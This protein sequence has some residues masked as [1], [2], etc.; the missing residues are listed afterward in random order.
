MLA[1]VAAGTTWA[2]VGPDCSALS[3]DQAAR[4]SGYVQQKYR[5]PADVK[6]TVSSV[7]DVGDCYQKLRFQSADPKRRFAVSLYLSPD[8]R[9]LTS[10]LN[11][12]SLNPAEEERKRLAAFRGE[13]E[14]GRDAPV[15]GP[16]E[17]QVSIVVFSDFQCP[18]CRAL[19]LTLHDVLSNPDLASKVRVVFRNLP[20]PMHAWAKQAAEVAACV[21]AQDEPSFWSLHDYL[22][23]HQKEMEAGNIQELGEY[24]AALP[25]L[26]AKDL[27][28]CLAD[29]RG[30]AT[31]QRD[32]SM[33]EENKVQSTPTLFINGF[34]VDGAAS[35]EQILTLVHEAA[36]DP[37]FGIR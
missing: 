23:S 7:E 30:L 26:S 6:I 16:E 9:F 37:T 19:A 27:A 35:R 32:V 4:L 20:L 12:S 25:G 8:H 1:V 31:I 15:L 5:L 10:D 28:G 24:A 21:R 22:F 34:R 3:S 33:A 14:D 17:A 2:N 11:D 29:H 18:Y 13:I 36:F